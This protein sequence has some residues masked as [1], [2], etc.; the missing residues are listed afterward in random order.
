MLHYIKCYHTPRLTLR[1]LLAGLMKSSS[2][3]GKFKWQKTSGDSSSGKQPFY[4]VKVSFRQQPTR[5]LGAKNAQNFREQCDG[6]FGEFPRAFPGVV[7]SQGWG[8]GR[9][10]AFALSSPR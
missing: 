5:T 6:S 10:G 2:M 8:V 9:A 7:T 4:E 3:M 1:L